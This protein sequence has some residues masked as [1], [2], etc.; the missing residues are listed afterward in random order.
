ME[1]KE[2][3]I[4]TIL[5]DDNERSMQNTSRY[6]THLLK[7]LAL[8]LKVTG[9]EDFS[10]EEPY[11]IGGWDQREYEK[12]KK[13]NQSYT[14]TFE[15]QD[16]QGPNEYEDIIA[17]VKRVSDGRVF[18]IGLSWLRCEDKETEAYTLLNDYAFWHTNY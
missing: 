8:P 12:L 2:R 17:K 16:I 11:V 13:T 1:A 14:D 15:L 18:E 4:H 10:W 5:G 3:R 6:R 9:I 7:H